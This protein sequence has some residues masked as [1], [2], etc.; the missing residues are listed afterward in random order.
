MKLRQRIPFDA[1]NLSVENLG[2]FGF[3]KETRKQIALMKCKY[4]KVKLNSIP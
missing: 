2:A 1:L 3:N 4:K